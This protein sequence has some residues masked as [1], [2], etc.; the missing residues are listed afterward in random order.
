M[1]PGLLARAAGASGD[2][3]VFMRRA[4]ELAAR[5]WGQTAPNPMVGAVA[6]RDG[7]VVG[8]GFHARYGD[9]HAE[10]VALRAAGELARGATLYVTLEPCTHHGK[11]PPCAPGVIAA[12]IARAVIATPDP[13][14]V[15]AGGVAMLRAAGLTVDVGAE[16]EAA[17]ELN[18]PFFHRFTSD[19][20]W[21]TVKL[22]LSSDGAIAAADRRP[23][24]LTGEESRREV[25]RQRA[26]ADA[27]AVGI[28]TVLA[29]DPLLTVRDTA[30]PRVAPARVVFDRSARLPLTS[31]LMTSLG[32][33]PVTV[34]TDGSAPE[35]E[36]S[37]ERAGASVIR[38]AG[39]AEA[40]RALRTGGVESLYVEGGAGLAGALLEA[41]LVDRLIIFQA[42][43]VLGG[44][45]LAAFAGAASFASGGLSRFRIVRQA[46]FGP[47][48]MTIYA[49]H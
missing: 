1:P 21:T 38:A 16:A 12:G 5:G 14:P 29:D 46:Q 28:G 23:T 30:P 26:A 24:W 35:R 39:T 11:R 2:D 20:P 7:E 22:A 9:E 31:R 3:L 27:I 40:L 25:H 32:D 48:E 4:L 45:S 44:G 41:R 43:V 36:R 17:L 42:P 10:P 37:L 18:A 34:V 19:R 6:V 49:L 13:N 8:E 33:A 47:D 15:A